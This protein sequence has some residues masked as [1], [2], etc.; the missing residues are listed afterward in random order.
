MSP[1]RELDHTADWALQIWAPSLEQL[2]TDAARGMFQ[3]VGTEAGEGPARR[4]TVRVEA[5]DYEALLVA[6]LQELLYQ[7]EAGRMAFDDYQIKSLTPTTLVAEAAG[8]PGAHQGSRIKAVTYHDLAIVC[9][10][11]GCTAS[12]VF[13]V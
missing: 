7:A 6:W 11:A 13:D 5:P 8:R 4:L 1:W 3:L 12:I 9:D 10:E 2:F